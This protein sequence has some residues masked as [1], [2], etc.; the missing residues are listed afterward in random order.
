MEFKTDK[1]ILV[2]GATGYISSY[3]IQILL[4]KGFKVRGSIRSLENKEKY[5]YL[6]KL[7]GNQNLSFVEASLENQ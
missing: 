7:E 1:P 3:I 2:T 6:Q 4:K 5:V